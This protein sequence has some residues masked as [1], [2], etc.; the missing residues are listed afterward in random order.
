MLPRPI[1]SASST[2]SSATTT[3]RPRWTNSSQSLIT[4]APSVLRATKRQVHTA[5]E[6]MAS[7]DGAWADALVLGAALA[8]PDA[9]AAARR[10]LDT[11]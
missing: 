10:Y 8:D 11:R 9:R 5:L 6:E 3:S 4:K 1:G 2:G 7:T